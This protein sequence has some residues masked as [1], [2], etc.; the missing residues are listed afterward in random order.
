[1]KFLERTLIVLGLISALVWIGVGHQKL[2]DARI[3]N[4]YEQGMAHG[5]VTG[6]T[7]GATMNPK[8]PTKQIQ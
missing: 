8:N 7:V 5:F 4:A 6:L 2:V 3:Q 1:M